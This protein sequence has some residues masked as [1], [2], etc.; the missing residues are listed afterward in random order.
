VGGVGSVKAMRKKC[1]L[2]VRRTPIGLGLFAGSP[3]PR[4]GLVCEYT[5]P[6]IPNSN[7]AR[8]KGRYLFEVNSRWTI[9]GS[10]R[11][12]IARYINHSCK[13]NCH[14]FARGRRV[15]I[16]A[17]KNIAAGEE[18]CYDY[19]KAYFDEF[20]KPKGCACPRCSGGLSLGYSPAKKRSTAA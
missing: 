20:I 11:D 16:Y 9:D 5:G 3:I 2:V 19:G 10:G 13:P 8:M 18:L 6:L 7:T 15:L 1:N 4:G 14:A 12:N 17:R